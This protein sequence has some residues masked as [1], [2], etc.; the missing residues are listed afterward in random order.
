MHLLSSS[1]FK[2]DFF[3]NDTYDLQS[4]RRRLLAQIAKTYLFDELGYIQQ[5]KVRRKD[6]D[7]YG[8]FNRFLD[9]DKP[10]FIYVE[11]PTALFHYRLRRNS[12]F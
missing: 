9:A 4:K 6:G 12:I 2:H 7:L 10:Y 1:D 5:I 3:V 8:S 11:N